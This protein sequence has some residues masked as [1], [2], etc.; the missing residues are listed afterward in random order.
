MKMNFPL[1]TLI[2][3][4]LEKGRKVAQIN[5]ETGEIIEVFDRIAD[6]GRKLNVNYKSIQK[7]IDKEERT[8]Y[9]YKWI[10]Q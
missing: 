4:V 1:K 6:A 10:S 5:V 7:V 9:G 2:N 3:I 8:A